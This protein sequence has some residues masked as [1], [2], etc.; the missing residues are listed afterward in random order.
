MSKPGKVLKGLCK[1]LGVRLTV[2]RGQKRVYKSVKVLKR[3]CANKKVVRRR[4]RNFG[5]APNVPT[6]KHVDQVYKKLLKQ[7][8]SN[9]KYFKKNSLVTMTIN[10]IIDQLDD[11]SFEKFKNDFEDLIVN[12]KKAYGNNFP[13]E[14]LKEPYNSKIKEMVVKAAKDYQNSYNFKG[15]DLEGLDMSE[16]D[17]NTEYLRFNKINL[18]GVNLE[19]ADL[20]GHI[21]K[22]TN[23][24]G[25]N[26]KNSEIGAEFPNAI[27]IGAIL[28]GANLR[29]GNFERAD[30]RGADLKN[31]KVNDL[32]SFN[33]T[34]LQGADLR[35]VDLRN[36]QVIWDARKPNFEGAIYNDRPI[37]INGK[38][39]EKTY[40]PEPYLPENQGMILD[41][42]DDPFAVGPVG[43][44]TS[45]Y[46]KRRKRK[47]LKRKRKKKKLKK[48]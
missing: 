25:A 11:T 10:E 3:Q 48:K 34:N 20:R 37:T 27:L 39:Y 18:E 12:I 32:T 41:N 16:Y 21:F 6:Q 17:M 22:G 45:F 40:L 38:Q 33:R 4:R 46:G 36:I 44:Y 7:K 1:K 14:L 26:L 23:L 47:K 29:Y 28:D 2:K 30:L 43:N 8:S 15:V 24:T 19:G 5:M 35:G 13:Y 31:I 42:N 9:Q